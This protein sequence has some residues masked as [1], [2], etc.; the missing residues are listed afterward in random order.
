MNE[1]GSG[2]AVGAHPRA[3][4]DLELA[5]RLEEAEAFTAEAYAR[6]LKRRRPTADVEVQEVAG[7]VSVFCG[8]G[9]PLTE[10]K[11]IG[12]HGPVS[13][14][15]LDRMEAVFFTRGEPSRVVVC[16]LA[17]P[18][19]VD[20]LGRRGYRV[21]SFENILVLPLSGHD[22]DP[23]PAPSIEIRRV[24]P[25]EVDLF[26]RVIGPNFA[27]PG[28]PM[29]DSLEMISTMFE[30]EHASSFL[31]LIDGEP[32][33]G[34]SLLLRRGLA[35]FAAQPPCRLIETGVSTLRCILL[36][37]PR[38][39]EWVA[40][41]RLKERSPAALPSATPSGGACESFTLGHCLC[42][43][44]LDCL[45]SQVP[46]SV[47]CPLPSVRPAVGYIGIGPGTPVGRSTWPPKTRMRVRPSSRQSAPSASMPSPRPESTRPPW[48]MF[49]H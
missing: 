43:I 49:S 19:L 9:S 27:A 2:L 5:R 16:P 41:W 35:L 28:A 30:M 37:W 14:A 45:G 23:A 36:V 21:S 34:G 1:S 12:L 40:T 46:A 18:S 8:A 47:P 13:E 31:A 44:Q 25:D 39:D 26:G 32:V 20:A 7:G 15:D 3:M 42:A 4:P 48:S 38:P 10:T 22:H 24:N 33:G 6:Q 29:D 17:D 11:A